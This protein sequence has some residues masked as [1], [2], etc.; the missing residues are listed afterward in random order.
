MKKNNSIRIHR[1]TRRYASV[2]YLFVLC[3]VVSILPFSAGSLPILGKGMPVSYEASSLRGG[4]ETIE[5]GVTQD[6]NS[7][8][9]ICLNRGS[10]VGDE[11]VI[12]GPGDGGINWTGQNSGVLENLFGVSYFGYT[13][14]LA[15]GASGTILFT[16]DTGQTWMVKQTGMMGSY[17]SGQMITDQIGVAVGVNAIYQPFVTRTN[18]GW[19]TWQSTSFYIEHDSVMYEGWLSDV[20]FMNESVGVATAVVDVPA[21]GAIVRTTDGGASWQTVYF[22]SEELYAVDFLWGDVG[23]AVGAQGT[24]LQS[25]DAGQ[26][27]NPLNSGVSSVLHDVDFPS[28]TVGFAVGESGVILR[29]DD[30][31]ITWTQQVSGTTENLLR[32]QSITEGIGVVV[33]EHGV[34]LRTTTGGYPPD[35]T[36]P[37]T[38]CTLT[39][40]MQGDVYTSNV[41]VLLSAT[42]NDTGVATTLY[43]LDDGFWNTYANPFVVT[44]DGQHLLHFYS[45]DNAGNAEQE[46]VLGFT[47]Q[48]PPKLAVTI[49]GGFGVHVTVKNLGPT[50]LR[51]ETWNLT[52]NGGLILLGRHVSGNA[53]IN[54]SDEIGVRTLVLGIGRTQITFSISSVETIVSGKVLL[55]F[56]RM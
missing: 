36:P 41:T 27:W 53:T 56:V 54:V 3:L 42:D 24:I 8:S 22:S 51:N 10:V 40:T 26:T 23:Y 5:S 16:N 35:S 32:M 13:L 52:L 2:V 44:A 34:I 25:L 43:K 7:V 17:F 31:G 45:I 6:L 33:G 30:A 11:G 50:T 19:T 55:F 38:T 1:L 4:W 20:Y 15:V 12:L 9:F 21:G 28:D 37:E 39:G 29:T 14:T 18:D 48:H 46:K 49:T 47:I